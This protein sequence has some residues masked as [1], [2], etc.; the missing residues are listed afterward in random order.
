ML[1]LVEHENSFNTSGLG[2]VLLGFS[3]CCLLQVCHRH[4][5]YNSKAGSYIKK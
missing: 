4:F 5:V 3:L 2:L 1:S